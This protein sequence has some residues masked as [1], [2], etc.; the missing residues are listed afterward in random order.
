MNRGWIAAPRTRDEKPQIPQATVGITTLQAEVYVP[1]G[2]AYMLDE[3]NYEHVVWPLV[4]QNVEI[5]KLSKLLKKDLF[6]Y[7]LRLQETDPN[8]LQANWQPISVQPEKHVAY[9]FQWFAMSAGLVMWFVFANTNL[10][11]W[12]TRKDNE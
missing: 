1:P 10:W 3:Q 4:I 5:K 6:S 8:L 12:I 11:Q 7:E 2:E 9:A